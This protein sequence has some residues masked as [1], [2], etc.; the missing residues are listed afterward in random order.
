[1][2]WRTPWVEDRCDVLSHVTAYLSTHWAAVRT[3]WLL[4][5]VPP[6]VNAPFTCRLTCQGHSPGLA[7]PPPTILPIKGAAPQ[8]GEKPAQKSSFTN[9][10]I[11]YRKDDCFQFRNLTFSDI[12]Y[13][14]LLKGHNSIENFERK[15]KLKIFHVL[16]VVVNDA[17]T[18]EEFGE[19]CSPSVCALLPVGETYKNTN[20]HFRKLYV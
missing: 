20:V 9:M 16:W 17:K 7:F 14:L 13:R 8:T 6:H 2:L 12:C 4:T 11:L 3:H 18:S 5:R 1:M 15:N 19:H 10:I